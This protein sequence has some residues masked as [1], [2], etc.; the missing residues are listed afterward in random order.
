MWKICIVSIFLLLASNAGAQ[1]V[2]VIKSRYLKTA[3]SALVYKPVNFD[4]A[5]KYPAVFLL[6]GHSGNFRSWSRLAD[7][8]KLADKHGM[9]II[10]PDGL[11]KSWYIDSPGNEGWDYESFFMKE[12][13]P[14]ASSRFRLDS[15]KLFV[16][17]ASMGGHGAMWL[18]LRHPEVFRSAGS[19]SGVL[20]LRYS[21]FKK[22]TLAALLGPYSEDNKLFDEY[23]AINQLE[24]IR[25]LQ[26]ELIFDCG[27]EDYLYP[28]NK[29]FRDRCDE[30]KIRATYIAR[31]GAHTG[32][33]WS[34]SIP[35][36]FEFFSRLIEKD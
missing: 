22:S 30:L 23:S 15:A 36:H 33:Y 12:L 2:L 26:K 8:Q 4:S 11:I 20:N 5:R 21:G 10:C 6:H 29:K 1:E 13:L 27:T 32:R 19:T 31:P 18:F 3:D 34:G 7:L 35:M 17:G 16:S 28:A 9:V 24:R 14:T 25:G